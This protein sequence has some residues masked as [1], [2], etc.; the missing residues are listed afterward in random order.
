VLAV[1]LLSSAPS[2][3]QDEVDGE[4]ATVM[5]GWKAERSAGAPGRVDL[6]LVLDGAVSS[7]IPI[8]TYRGAPLS[9]M[10]AEPAILFRDWWAGDEVVVHV[11]REDPRHLAVLESSLEDPGTSSERARLIAIPEGVFV[12]GV[13]SRD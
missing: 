10:S 8:G 12:Q 5:V 1:A 2:S 3:P 11:T 9:A 7:E 6:T 4:P 13:D